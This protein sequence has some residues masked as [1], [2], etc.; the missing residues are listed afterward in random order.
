MV[1]PVFLEG[2]KERSDLLS[3]VFILPL[4]CLMNQDHRWFIKD[5]LET[6]D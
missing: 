1:Y 3:V 2:H 5:R 6:N 4:W